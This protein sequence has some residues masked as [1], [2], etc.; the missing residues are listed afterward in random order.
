VPT[1]STSDTPPVRRVGR[2]PG[3]TPK[4]RAAVLDA[5]R[6]ELIEQGYRQFRVDRVAERA[7]VHRSTLYRHWAAPADLA[8]EAIVTWEIA[9]IPEAAETGVWSVDL[10]NLCAAFRDA[11]AA[12]EGVT[13]M[14]TLVVANAIDTQLRDALMERWAQPD[15]LHII[16]RAQQRGEVTAT[17]DAAA[18]VELIAAPFVL[19]AI[20][21]MMELDDSFVEVVA[22]SVEAT[23]AT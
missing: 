9:S 12:P 15:I 6:D 2:P 11:L 18:V 5:A 13:L 1:T 23:T 19:R 16:E 22:S 7:G 10:R 14:R 20:I 21:T 4:V 17:V 3:I 8:R